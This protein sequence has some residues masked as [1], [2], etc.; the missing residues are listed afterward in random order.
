MLCLA[1]LNSLILVLL[2]WYEEYLLEK[3]YQSPLGEAFQDKPDLSHGAR[4][5]DRLIEWTLQ[6]SSRQVTSGCMDEY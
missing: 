4:F 2:K 3:P 1:P 6:T 5:P